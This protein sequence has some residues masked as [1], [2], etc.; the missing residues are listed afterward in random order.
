MDLTQSRLFISGP[1]SILSP[2]TF[3]S[4]GQEQEL[5]MPLAEIQEN[6]E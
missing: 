3:G 1:F 4:L 2:R 5:G 6:S